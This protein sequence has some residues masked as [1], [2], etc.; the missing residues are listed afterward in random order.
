MSIPTRVN[1]AIKTHYTRSDLGNVILAALEKT[2]K[3]VNRLS[4]EDLA[5][6]DEFHSLARSSWGTGFHLWHGATRHRFMVHHPVVPVTVGTGL[7]ADLAE[8]VS[9]IG[10]SL[11]S[12]VRSQQEVASWHDALSP[13]IAAHPPAGV[14]V[15]PPLSTRGYALAVLAFVV[16]TT[17]LVIAAVTAVVLAGS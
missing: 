8:G 4:P 7:V 10:P 17:L 6:V 13:V 9:T 5:P 2:G 15:R 1:E 12:H 14:R 11:A 16:A 3:D